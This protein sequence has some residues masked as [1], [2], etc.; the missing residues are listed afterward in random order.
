MVIAAEIGTMWMN[1]SAHSFFLA[2]IICH[3]FLCES[4]E[5]FFF[6]AISSSPYSVKCVYKVA[7]K[8]VITQNHKISRNLNL[9][10]RSRSIVKSQSSAAYIL[11]SY[12]HN[13]FALLVKPTDVRDYSI[14]GHF[15]KFRFE[16]AKMNLNFPQYFL[17]KCPLIRSCT[18][19][20]SSS[21]PLNWHLKRQLSS[22]VAPLCAFKIPVP[23]RTRNL[24]QNSIF[25]FSL[26]F[27]PCQI[28]RRRRPTG[29][30]LPWFD[31]VFTDV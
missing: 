8:G 24:S 7:H 19:R 1:L 27:H 25:L 12:R 6:V 10:M 15:K 5:E 26:L 3:H 11:I 23:K 16:R 17:Q 22:W 4:F 2:F 9:F 30:S 14:Q 31:S 21:S 18:F 28:E 29:E 20:S 13:R